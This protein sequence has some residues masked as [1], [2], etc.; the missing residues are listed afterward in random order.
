MDLKNKTVFI[1]GASEGLGKSIAEKLSEEKANLVLVARNEKRL[2]E[3][4]RNIKSSLVVPCDITKPDQVKKAVDEAIKKFGRIDVLVN[5]A[6]IWYKTK[7]IEKAS[8]EEIKSVIDVNLTGTINVT[9]YVMP[10]LKKNKESYIINVSSHSGVKAKHLQSVYCGAKFGLRGFTEAL[11]LELENT[12]V[13]VVGFYPSGMNTEMFAKTGESFSS[14]DFMKTED[15][16]DIV[17]FI[18]KQPANI[19]IEEIWIDKFSI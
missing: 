3:V 6:G 8:D 5:S 19:H 2:D 11:K 18:I 13:R 4:A 14:K 17:R 10:L 16:A 12:G 9:K 1:T 7:P 15:I